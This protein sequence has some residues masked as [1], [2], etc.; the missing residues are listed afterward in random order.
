MAYRLST[1]AAVYFHAQL[2]CTVASH[3]HHAAHLGTETLQRSFLLLQST[4]LLS[5]AASLA[6]TA[7][8]VGGTS[9]KG[10]KTV[11]AEDE[12]EQKPSSAAQADANESDRQ[13]CT[14]SKQ[15]CS[16]LPRKSKV[17]EDCQTASGTGRAVLCAS[18]RAFLQA[19]R[20]ACMQASVCPDGAHDGQAVQ[21]YVL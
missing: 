18:S 7:G 13:A 11:F 1:L 19:R 15:Q 3:C 4:P 10:Q 9:W 2:P 12:H 5:P 17:E 21:A 6:T 16:Q 14:W 20:M 8:K